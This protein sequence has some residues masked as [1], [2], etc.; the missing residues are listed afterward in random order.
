MKLTADSLK[1]RRIELGLSQNDIAN[2]A[3]VCRATIV[4]LESEGRAVM[5]DIL[6]AY[7]LELCEKKKAEPLI[8]DKTERAA[9]RAW[10][11]ASHLVEFQI[12]VDDVEDEWYQIDGRIEGSTDTHSISFQG[13]INGTES[14]RKYT[15]D[16]LCGEEE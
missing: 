14:G 1:H 8:K 15:L 9:I 12:A 3:G 6:D 13:A 7:E 11:K 5:R 2:K 16:E 10:A 4:N